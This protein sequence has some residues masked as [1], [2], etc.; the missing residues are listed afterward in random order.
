M[1]IS[2]SQSPRCLVLFNQK[3]PKPKDIQFT[4]K[5]QMVSCGKL[6]PKSVALLILFIRNCIT[7]ICFDLDP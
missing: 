2:T 4:L 5:Q 3:S 7:L 6:E 1:P